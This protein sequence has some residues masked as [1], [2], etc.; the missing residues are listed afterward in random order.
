MPWV[1]DRT[2]C[3]HSFK[4]SFINSF[5]CS[6][7]HSFIHSFT[8]PYIHS[9]FDRRSPLTIHVQ[10]AS[11]GEVAAQSPSLPPSPVLLAS[12]LS[13]SLFLLCSLWLSFLPVSLSLSISLWQTPST[14]LY[15]L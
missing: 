8:H 4:R 15:Y 13:C 1:R 10:D 14:R 6:F 12:P 3:Y 9:S 5:N 11:A 7:I 2:D